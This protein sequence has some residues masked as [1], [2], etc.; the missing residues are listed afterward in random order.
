MSEILS[1]ISVA[2]LTLGGTV[3]VLEYIRYKRAESAANFIAHHANRDG[4]PGLRN[5]LA[6]L[7]ETGYCRIEFIETIT[8]PTKPTPSSI[9]VAPATNP[10]V[11]NGVS[12]IGGTAQ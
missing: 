10:N 7:I 9:N 11:A 3:C 12:P 5:S 2:L 8:I 4:I 1:S 6:H